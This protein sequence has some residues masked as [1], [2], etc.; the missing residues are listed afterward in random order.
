MKNL[1]EQIDIS[2]KEELASINSKI[3]GLTL[4]EILKYRIIDSL[5]ENISS[6]SLDNLENSKIESKFEDENR[7]INIKIQS[8]NSS[9]ADLNSTIKND[10]LFICINQYNNISIEDFETKKKFNFK[11][12][13]MTGIVLS[14]GL[15]WTKD[16]KKNSIILELT[17]E[18]KSDNIEK[19]S[20]STIYNK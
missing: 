11:C 9:S 14:K 16:Y 1:S 13:P 4:L 6:I 5:K 12:I 2:I 19:I 18:D 8:F 17:L 10:M 15:N 3:N 20:E 7:K